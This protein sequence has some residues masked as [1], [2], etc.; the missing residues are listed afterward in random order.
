M[1]DTLMIVLCVVAGTLVGI[2][3]GLFFALEVL[4]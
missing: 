2:A 3:V 1:T 4:H